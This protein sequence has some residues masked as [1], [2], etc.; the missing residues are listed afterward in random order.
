MTKLA[1][2]VETVMADSATKKIEEE[3]KDVVV[4]AVVEVFGKSW[5]CCGWELLVRKVQP[6]PLPVP[7]KPEASVVLKNNSESLDAPAKV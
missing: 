6:S 7:S 1:E 4:S 3:I 2:V 5:S